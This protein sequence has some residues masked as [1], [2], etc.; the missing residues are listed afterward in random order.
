Q[1]IQLLTTPENSIQHN[2]TTLLIIKNSSLLLT[3]SALFAHNFLVL[4]SLL[5]LITKPSNTSLKSLLLLFHLVKSIDCMKS[6]CLTLTFNTFPE[7][8]T[9][10]QMPY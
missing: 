4:N 5:L 6:L 1:L 10:S 7:R 9:S 3:P 2:A 8:S